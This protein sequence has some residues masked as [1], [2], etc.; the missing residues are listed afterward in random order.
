[1]MMHLQKLCNF[2][3]ISLLHE[4]SKKLKI[5]LELLFLKAIDL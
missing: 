5:L 2:V 4:D 1:M 3:F